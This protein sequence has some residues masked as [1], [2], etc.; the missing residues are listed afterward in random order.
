MWQYDFQI[1]YCFAIPSCLSSH[2]QAFFFFP[3]NNT[4]FFRAFLGSHGKVPTSHTPPALTHA[5]PPHYHIPTRV[6]S[7]F[8]ITVPLAV[9]GDA[10]GPDSTGSN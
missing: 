2:F 1:Q 8:I 10:Q 5:Q 9:L 7:L 4:L 3:L 6:W